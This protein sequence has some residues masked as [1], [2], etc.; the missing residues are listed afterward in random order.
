MDYAKP[1]GFITRAYFESSGHPVGSGGRV[2]Q[3][4]VTKIPLHSRNVEGNVYEFAVQL[5]PG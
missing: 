3:F 5:K 2:T 4:L 1:R